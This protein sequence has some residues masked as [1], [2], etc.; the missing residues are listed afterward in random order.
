MWNNFVSPFFR[1]D[2]EVGQEF[3]LS[4]ILS[5]LYI[6]LIFHIFEKRSRNPILNLPISFHSFEDNSLLIP[7]KN[8]IKS[9]MSFFCK[10][11]IISFL[12]NQFSLTIKYRKSEV[13]YF[14]RSTKNF[15]SFPLDLSLLGGLILW[16]NNIWKYLGF[17]FSRKLSFWQQIWYYSNKT[18]S[19]IEDM[20]ILGNSS[21]DLLPHYK[22]LLYRTSILLIALYRFLL[23]Y[24][25][26]TLLFHSL[27]EF[28]KIQQSAAI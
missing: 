18:L 28:R 14:S 5:A 4:P 2:V 6:V 26:S 17:H 10:Y 12:F 13:F 21:R 8:H 19:T 27:K 9:Q 15:N 1:I 22:W 7:K 11:N 25:K 20:K 16:P 24:F 3:A 23:W